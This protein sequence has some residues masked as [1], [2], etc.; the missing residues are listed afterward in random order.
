MSTTSTITVYD[1]SA[2]GNT[3]L[4]VIDSTGNVAALESLT[5]VVVTGSVLGG[6]LMLTFQA[7][8]AGANTVSDGFVA[9]A[10]VAST[11]RPMVMDRCSELPR[12]VYPEDGYLIMFGPSA[13]PYATHGVAVGIVNL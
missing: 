12:V 10:S 8:N 11:P 4:Q 1:T 13:G 5:A 9:E 6:S 7:G 2:T 3:V